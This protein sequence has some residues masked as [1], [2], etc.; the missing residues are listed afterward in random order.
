MHGQVKV[1]L[2]LLIAKE[3]EKKKLELI[4]EISIKLSKIFAFCRSQ[5]FPQFD[6]DI[7]G[8]ISDILLK[9]ASFLTLWNFRREMLLSLKLKDGVEQFEK[10]LKKDLILTYDALKN[11]P[12]SYGAWHHRQWVLKNFSAPNFSAE[13]TVCDSALKLDERNFHCWDF[14]RFVVERG[15]IS[16][17]EETKFSDDLIE[18]NFSNFSAW[19]YRGSLLGKS[20]NKDQYLQE[21]DLAHNAIFTDPNDQSPWVY[22][23]C[24]YSKNKPDPRIIH[25]SFDDSDRILA[26]SFDQVVDR[27]F[28]VSS[29]CFNK[30]GSAIKSIE[31]NWISCMPSDWSSTWYTF[32]PSS[33]EY[34]TDIIFKVTSND[35]SVIEFNISS[36]ESP[37]QIPFLITESL[38]N[39][40]L[41]SKSFTKDLVENEIQLINELLELEPNNKWALLTI[42]KLAHFEDNSKL[43]PYVSEYLEL[44]MK[45]DPQRCQYY[46]ELKSELSFV[47]EINKFL[48]YANSTDSRPKISFS[49]LNLTNL[50]HLN[51][52]SIVTELDFSK[53]A[54][55]ILPDSISCLCLLKRLNLDDNLIDNVTWLPRLR[56]LEELSIKRNRINSKQALAD[57]LYT[58]KSIKLVDVTENP[59]CSSNEVHGKWPK[60]VKI[61][62]Q[63]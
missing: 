2:P 4:N 35:S 40:E 5:S 15:N 61:I 24:L 27:S 50:L 19:H 47:A 29:H 7:H 25:I 43:K 13:I 63:L 55:N 56:C 52:L 16:P 60:S 54:L 34:S 38:L 11:D 21:L 32:V 41:P 23:W 22:L 31:L 62:P 59:V 1:K 12:K 14:R 33:E 53:N 10:F 51:W 30:D 58:S 8:A 57:A 6:Q 44:L 17:L 36:N 45:H 20:L 9:E 28:L 37:H 39:I 46:Q 18:T 42:L 49:G 48:A 3:A 26:I